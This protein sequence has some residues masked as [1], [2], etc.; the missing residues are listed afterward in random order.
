MFIAD[1]GYVEMPHDDFWAGMY[2]KQ[3]EGKRP[4]DFEVFHFIIDKAPDSPYEIF[5]IPPHLMFK[6][7]FEAGLR[8]I[9][10]IP[11]YPDPA[12]KDDKVMRRYLDKCGPSDYL[13]KF[14]FAKKE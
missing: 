11:Q 6:A 8:S 7:G 14:K 1:F 12:Y 2:T 5:N 9:E 10:H 13:M 3:P 4:G